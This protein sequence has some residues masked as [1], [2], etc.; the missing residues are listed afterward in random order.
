MAPSS[1]TLQ[2]DAL[3]TTTLR[4]YRRKLEDNISTA[5]AFL[6]YLMKIEGA[7]KEISDL[8]ERMQMPLMYELGNADAYSGLNL[9]PV[10]G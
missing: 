8:G 9:A 10:V 5:N 1:E 4:N 6:F 7:Y 2:Y 3:L